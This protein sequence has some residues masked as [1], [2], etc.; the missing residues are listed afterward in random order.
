[1]TAE[2]SSFDYDQAL[3]AQE[4][5]RVYVGLHPD[6]TATQ[7]KVIRENSGL[8]GLVSGEDLPIGSLDML[9]TLDRDFRARK[10]GA[11]LGRIVS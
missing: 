7:I 2:M 11:K 9:S 6:L 3:A 1:M 10:I 5:E 4:F 8:E